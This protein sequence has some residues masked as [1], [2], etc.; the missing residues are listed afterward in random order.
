[1]PCTATQNGWV[2]IVKSSDKIWSTGG[3]KWQTTPVV[4]PEEPHEQYEKSKRA[5]RAAFT[6]S[7]KVG[8]NLA[9]EQQQQLHTGLEL[10]SKAHVG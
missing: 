5:W 1:M 3:E 6:E 9:T 4:L 10:S 7:Q 2:Y 8:H